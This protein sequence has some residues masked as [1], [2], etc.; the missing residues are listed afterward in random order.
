MEPWTFGYLSAYS[1]KSSGHN[2]KSK[3]VTKLMSYY[4]SSSSLLFGFDGASISYAGYETYY[5]GTS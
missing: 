4:I 3:Y 1:L 2:G 5:V